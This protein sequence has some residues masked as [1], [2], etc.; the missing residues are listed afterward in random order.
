[1]AVQL[2]EIDVR[3]LKELQ[4]DADRPNV[5]AQESDADSLL[6]FVRQLCKLRSS[7]RALAP[8]SAR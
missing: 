2:D 7:C 3:L 4:E 8:V 6:N 1:M 5:E